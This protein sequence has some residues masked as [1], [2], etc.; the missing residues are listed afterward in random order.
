MSLCFKTKD[1]PS[2]PDDITIDLAYF[3][4]ENISF[5]NIT[6]A[7]LERKKSSTRRIKERIEISPQYNE[8]RN[9]PKENKYMQLIDDFYDCNNNML[10]DRRGLL[11]ELIVKQTRPSPET[12][13]CAIIP[14]SWIY[15]DGSKISEKDIDV[16]FLY[17][18][19]QLIECKA[20]IRN[21]GGDRVRSKLEFMV[22]VKK[23]ADKHSIIC[24]L[25]LATY[26]INVLHQEIT[27]SNLGFN[28]ISII[29]RDK[30]IERLYAC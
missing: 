21:L 29:S 26:S 9:H 17:N 20:I 11:L 5:A 1:N 30:I 24:S 22:K 27:L 19:V 25:Y 10:A 3:I 8:I 4:V 15:Y 7:T 28:S 12:Y 23:L 2:H 16:V 6:F 13:R 18:E 14:E